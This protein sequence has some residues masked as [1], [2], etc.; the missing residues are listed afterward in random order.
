MVYAACKALDD[1]R[2]GKIAQLDDLG[3]FLINKDKGEATTVDGVSRQK[4]VDGLVK[5]V[6]S[7]NLADAKD[8][9]EK[10]ASRAGLT[11]S[12]TL[13]SIG[14]LDH[15]NDAAFLGGVYSVAG[16]AEPPL[17]RVAVNVMTLINTLPVSMSIS[18]PSTGPSSLTDLM[19]EQRRNLQSLLL[20]NMGVDPTAT[21]AL[22]AKH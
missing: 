2:A 19:S 10:G 14:L 20:A 12:V 6:P 7:L 18:R 5:D 15:N 22:P 3:A 4:Y 1:L 9:I 21:T 8:A 11:V 17:L 16:T 13:N